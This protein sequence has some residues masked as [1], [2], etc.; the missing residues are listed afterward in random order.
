MCVCACAIWRPVVVFDPKLRPAPSS[1]ICHGNRICWQRKSVCQLWCQ[2][3]HSSR[4]HHT[5]VLLYWYGNCQVSW[6][7]PPKMLE[8]IFI[9]WARCALSI[10]LV[11]AVSQ[12]RVT[13]LWAQWWTPALAPSQNWRFTSPPCSKGTGLPTLVYRR[14]LNQHW[15]ARCLAASSSS[16]WVGQHLGHSLRLFNTC[17]DSLIWRQVWLI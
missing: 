16:P 15:L 4:L 12:H 13:S 6:H 7:P 10:I 1:N 11:P 5:S 9:Q 8:K 3:C 17:S 14:L 2:V